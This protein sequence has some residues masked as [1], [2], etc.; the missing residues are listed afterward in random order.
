M[1]TLRTRAV[2]GK[3]RKET[4]CIVLADDTCEAPKVRLN[5]GECTQPAPPLVRPQPPKPSPAPPL[6]LLRLAPT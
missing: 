4:V 5:R 6:A 1:L 3:R 2:Q